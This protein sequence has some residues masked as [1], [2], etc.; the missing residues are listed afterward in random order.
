MIILKV[1]SIHKD[2]LYY[3][4]YAAINTSIALYYYYA[5]QRWIWYTN[6]M[7]ISLNTFCCTVDV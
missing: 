2:L 7:K 1:K 4:Y 6:F 3:D 5:I